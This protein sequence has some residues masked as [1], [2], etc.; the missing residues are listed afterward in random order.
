[1]QIPASI[2]LGLLAA[3]LLPP[4]PHREEPSLAEREA[5][6]EEYSR[7]PM[8]VAGG[9]VRPRWLDD[10][11]SLWY[12]DGTQALFLDPAEGTPR[13]ATREDRVRQ[14]RE[15][16]ESAKQYAKEAVDG[17]LQPA[18]PPSGG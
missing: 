13:P 8:L 4:S 5:L 12:R 15:H 16:A 3:S 7:V 10:G 14:L 11:S 2:V 6:C 9:T 17:A 1:M 18:A